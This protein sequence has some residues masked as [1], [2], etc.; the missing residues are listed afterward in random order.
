MR[1]GGGGGGCRGGWGQGV[2]RGE[3]E[4]DKEEARMPQT[5][6]WSVPPRKTTLGARTARSPVTSHLIG[7]VGVTSISHLIGK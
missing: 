6:P 1:G 4:G 5:E 2:E 7:E 3:K